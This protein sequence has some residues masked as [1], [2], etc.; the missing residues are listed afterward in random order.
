[1]VAA[2]SSVMVAERGSRGRGLCVCV[3]GE[4]VNIL[5]VYAQALHCKTT[6]TDILT[7]FPSL[8]I[9]ELISKA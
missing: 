2:S 6:C 3:C 4:V 1:M 9:P 8:F 5:H 7:V